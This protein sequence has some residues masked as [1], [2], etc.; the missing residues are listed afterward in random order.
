MT[1]DVLQNCPGCAMQPGQPHRDWHATS[2]QMQLIG[3]DLSRK[4]QEQERW[5]I[6][7]MPDDVLQGYGAR[8][9]RMVAMA[10]ADELP[11]FLVDL[12]SDWLEQAEKEWR[13]RSRAA[14]L[15]ADAVKRS[16][17]W[18]IRVET[19]KREADLAMLIAYENAAAKP[20]GP[21]KW[22]CACPFHADD[23]ASLSI[24]VG[25]G[26]WHCFGCQAGGDAIE[27]VKR[28]TGLGFAD[29]VRHLEDRLGIAP[30]SAPSMSG[31]EIPTL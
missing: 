1:V 3:Q 25:R 13:W 19:V 15:G 30:P 29:A 8:L 24:N 6:K 16:D 4:A 14:R 27:Y 22:M 28:S 11:D 2:D 20:A 21:G 23:R 31:V 17:I 9:R 12:T 7:Q 10:E 18:A 26:V 5:D